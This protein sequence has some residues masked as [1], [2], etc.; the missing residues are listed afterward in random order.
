MTAAASNA[1]FWPTAE[2]TLLLKVGLFPDARAVEA[3]ERWTKTN[4]LVE[5]HLDA[6]TFRLLPLAYRNLATLGHED[7]WMPRLKG[8]YRYF[9]SSNQ[10][11]F[12]WSASLIRLLHDEGLRTLIL[13]G[14]AMSK[15]HYRDA[16]VRPM[17]DVDVL[18]PWTEVRPALRALSGAGWRSNTDQLEQDLK[19]RHSVEMVNGRLEFDL[20]WHVLYECLHPDDDEGVWAR[21][22]PVE[23]AGVPTRAMGPEDTLLHT[24]VHGVADNPVA[25]VRWIADAAT[26]VNR[27]GDSLDWGLIVGEAERRRVLLRLRAGLNYLSRKFSV[28]VPDSALGGGRVRYFEH[29]EFRYMGL[30]AEQRQTFFSAFLPVIAAGYVRLARGRTLRQNLAD[31]V[32]FFVHR[33]DLKGTSELLRLTARSFVGKL[34]KLPA[35]VIG[36]RTNG[37]TDTLNA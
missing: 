30:T 33:L 5:T 19:F 29:V 32:P 24:I 28:D 23:F 9:W 34:R 3:W 13:K 1:T 4:D 25:P 18:V 31:L 8:I 15:L 35:L 27:H 22:Q 12:H 14:A 2:Q 17:R 6:A 11:L 26:L 10:R 36:S 16:A 20:H 21:S 7:E 37:R